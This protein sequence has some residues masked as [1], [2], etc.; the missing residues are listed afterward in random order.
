[1]LPKTLYHASSKD[2]AELKPGFLVTGKLVEWDFGEN[3]QYLYAVES[4][5]SVIG[6]GL[7]SAIEKICLIDRY[8][9]RD[10]NIIV[11][12]SEGEKAPSMEKIYSLGLYVYSIKTAP[13]QL[14]MKNNNEHNGLTDEWKT[15]AKIPSKYFTVEKIDVKKWLKDKKLH[16]E[17]P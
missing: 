11:Y 3:N 17:L 6:L 14:W 5:E 16:F 4:K 10:E 2:V 9:I 1:M 15:K 13:E 7:G 12:I 8:V